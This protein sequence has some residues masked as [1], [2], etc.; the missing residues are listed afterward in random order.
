MQLI[1]KL[2]L[3]ICFIAIGQ[4]IAGQVGAR[5]K[6]NFNNFSDWQGFTND[7]GQEI[8]FFPTNI[9]VGI[10][11]W[12]RLKNYRLEFTPE[13]SYGLSSSTDVGVRSSDFSYF[14]FLFNTQIYAFDFAGD[15]DCPTFSKQG[16]TLNKGLFFNLAPGLMYSL[17]DVTEENL[18]LYENTSIS[19]RLGLGLGYDIGVN[20]LITITPMVSYFVNTSLGHQPVSR[21][22]T[23]NIS[24]PEIQDSGLN[25][26]QFQIRVGF[27]PDYVK[28]YG[29]G[30]RRR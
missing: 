27:R 10:D 19:F 21:L 6:Y 16:P 25:Q 18:E 26:L 17:N 2:I 12:F 23:G 30:R 22:L 9:E 28:S 4:S 14:S 7:N 15:C 13:I 20:D 24:D 1:R 29:G 3:L 11:Y 8:D 5:V